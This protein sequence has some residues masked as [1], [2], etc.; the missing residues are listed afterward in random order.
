MVLQLGCKLFPLDLAED[1]ND[2]LNLWLWKTEPCVFLVLER[3]SQSDGRK[4][5]MLDVVSRV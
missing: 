3:S 2:Q 5:G 4:E 1:V